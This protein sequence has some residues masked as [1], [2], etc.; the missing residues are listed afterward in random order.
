MTTARRRALAAVAALVAVACA[1]TGW[2]LTRDDPRRPAA[3]A[4]SVAEAE[5]E[6]AS[7]CAAAR[8]FEELV[9][10]NARLDAVRAELDAALASSERAARSDN[11]W[12]PLRSGLQAVDVALR[13]DDA[14]AARTG[15][16]VVR[17]E[18]RRLPA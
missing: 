14:R 15:I 4:L 18:C 1:A 11:R 6:A 10:A 7:A 12:V 17:S 8:R 3:P 2:A 16:G 9:A 13:A 5:R